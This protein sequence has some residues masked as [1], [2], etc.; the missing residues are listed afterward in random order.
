MHAIDTSQRDRVHGPDQIETRQ[1]FDNLCSCGA[2]GQWIGNR[3][4]C[5]VDY[6]VIRYADGPV[7]PGD[8]EG[9]SSQ[10]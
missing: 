1:A 10:P 7:C 4:V 9:L 6:R 8:P 5:P 2:L 3:L